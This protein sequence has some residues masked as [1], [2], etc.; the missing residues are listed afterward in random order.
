MSTKTIPPLNEDHKLSIGIA[1]GLSAA[2]RTMEARRPDFERLPGFSTAVLVVQEIE[3]QHRAEVAGLNFRAAAAAGVDIASHM[4]GL[5][6][7]GE[8]YADEM[9]LV[10]RSQFAGTKAEA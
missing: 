8:I 5:R 1:L 4:V 2:L 7:R 6:G 10:Q 9:D 3:A